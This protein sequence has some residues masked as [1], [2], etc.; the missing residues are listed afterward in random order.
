MEIF[1]ELLTILCF[2]TIFWLLFIK[3][4]RTTISYNSTYI[5]NSS[6]TGKGYYIGD[7]FPFTTI[8]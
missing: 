8:N 4:S 2:I 3:E 7:V 1:I 6:W 5:T